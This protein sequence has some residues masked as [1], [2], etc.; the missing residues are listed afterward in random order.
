MEF[1]VTPCCDI[2][3]VYRTQT[4]AI[5]ESAAPNLRHRWWNCDTREALAI[6]E[7]TFPNL[8]FPFRYYKRSQLFLGKFLCNKCEAFCT[9]ESGAIPESIFPNLLHRWGDGDTRETGTAPES[10]VPNLRHRWWDGDTS[11]TGATRES[12][13][14]NLRH[15]WGG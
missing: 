14:P 3:N 4:L 7:S 8:R 1:Y 6:R 12:P 2:R 15:R 11:E 13:V 10:I 9:R 5:F